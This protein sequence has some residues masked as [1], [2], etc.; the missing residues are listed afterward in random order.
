MCFFKGYM[1]LFLGARFPAESRSGGVFQPAAVS[2]VITGAPDGGRKQQTLALRG[3]QAPSWYSA[4][5]NTSGREEKEGSTAV[6][7]VRDDSL[8]VVLQRH[9]SS[10]A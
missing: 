6:A 10:G 1:L 3:C 5:R 8:V 4:N 2:T 7:L 9:Q